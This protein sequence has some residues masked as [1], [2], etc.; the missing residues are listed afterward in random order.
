VVLGSLIGVRVVFV[1]CGEVIG[2]I[3]IRYVA[4]VVEYVVFAFC[5]DIVKS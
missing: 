3:A 2:A 1:V 5:V 4:A